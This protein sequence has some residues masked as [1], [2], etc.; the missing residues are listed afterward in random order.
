MD[1]ILYF[2]YYYSYASVVRV[3]FRIGA[4]SSELA[5]QFQGLDS[6]ATP[7]VQYRYSSSELRKRREANEQI[8]YGEAKH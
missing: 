5:A 3:R 8:K 1:D 2:T 6:K 4:P 7:A